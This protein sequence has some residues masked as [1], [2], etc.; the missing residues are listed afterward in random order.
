VRLILIDPAGRFAA[1]SLPQGPGN[2]GTAEVRFPER[3]RW[4]GVIFSKDSAHGGST[5][6]MPWRMATQQF[7]PF[8]SVTPNRLRLA[9]D[10]TRTFSVSTVTP[11][12]PGDASGSIV[13]DSER[14][15]QTTVPVTLRSRV[16]VPSGGTFSGALRGGN[17]RSPGEGQVQYYEFNVP[18]GVRDI[19]ADVVFANDPAN[20]VGSYLISPDGATAGYGQNSAGGSSFNALSAYTLN[21]VPGTWTLIVDFAEPVVGNEVSQPYAGQIRFN[22]VDVHASGVPNGGAQT[23]LPAGKPATA[24]ITIHN[25][26]RAPEGFFVDPRLNRATTFDL[27]SPDPA[28]TLPLTSQVPVWLV[29]TQL[30]S[31]TAAQASSVPTMFD[32]APSGLFFVPS[33]GDPDIS[34]A[35]FGPGPLCATSESASYSPAGGKVTAGVWAAAPTGCGPY[36]PGG[37]HPG[38]VTNGITAQGKPFDTS[39]TSDTS[40]LWLQSVDP[41]AT[42][43]PVVIQPGQTGT[44]NVTFTPS[45]AKGSVVNGTLYLDDI[46]DAVPAYYQFSGDELAA[47]PYSYTIK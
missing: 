43:S 15:G 19:T 22:V 5:G 7:A 33:I 25:T 3:G 20:P 1:H 16:E 41:S 13:I 45:G 38:T 8:A 34:S 46:T 17:G 40:D 9:P 18:A 36:P 10:Q 2:F 32:F 31:I 21:P 11:S 4:T 30:S 27:V 44:I 24:T 26:S 37:A 14:D 42:V 12:Q 35:G 29:P 28:N 47:V 6:T 39:V 23:S